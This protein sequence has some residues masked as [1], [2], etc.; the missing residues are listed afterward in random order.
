[1][2]K[3]LKITGWILLIILA[4]LIIALIFIQ[5]RPGK[6]LITDLILENVNGKLQNAELSIQRLDVNYLS[7]LSL[8]GVS[9]SH[10]GENILSLKEFRIHYS[11]KS[12]MSNRITIS[13]ILFDELNLILRQDAEGEWNLISILPTAAQKV[14]PQKETKNSNWEIVLDDFSLRNSEIKINSTSI[15]DIMLHFAGKYSEAESYINLDTFSFNSN[16]PDLKLENL[17]FMAQLENYKV[18]LENMQIRTAENL[19]TLRAEI[20]LDDLDNG[21]VNINSDS[22]NLTEFSGFIPLEDIKMLPEIN[23]G[24]TL[25]NQNADFNLEM[26]EAGQRLNVTGTVNSVFGIPD[27]R[28]KLAL[29]HLDGDHW[30]DDPQYD[31]DINLNL[32]VNGKG[33][34]LE[35]AEMDFQFNVKPSYMGDHNVNSIV[36]TGHKSGSSADFDT[37]IKGDFGKINISGAAADIF[38]EVSYHLQGSLEG[39]DLAKLDINDSLYSDLNLEF[40]VTG[41]G[42]DPELLTT[43]LKINGEHSTLMGMEINTLKADI[44]YEKGEYIVRD[45]QVMNPAAKLILKAD[46]NI[47]GEHNLDF[48]LLVNDLQSISKLVNAETLDG[49]G[50]IRGNI[51]INNES[52][53]ANVNL[54]MKELLYNEFALG[55]ISGEIDLDSELKKTIDAKLDMKDF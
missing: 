30:L 12:I 20:D 4:L 17:E 22:L 40:D 32:T 50:E 46:G 33:I 25:K 55:E 10:E 42:S 13:G 47:K 1:M 26:N 35:K 11:L 36:L 48:N 5:T 18:V 52:Y 49:S 31:S 6:N 34:E 38:D 28:L 24:L 3:V 43:D 8:Q 16:D 19:I 44:H 7:S 9:I 15:S 39:L 51:T 45:L 14:K 2:R 53:K 27:Y 21:F 54:S 23:L 41:E 29:E 37:D